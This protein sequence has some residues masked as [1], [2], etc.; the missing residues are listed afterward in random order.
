MSNILILSAGRRV[1]LLKGFQDA[2][3]RLGNCRVL[4]ADADPQMRAACHIADQAFVLPRVT[5]RDYPLALK[6]LCRKYDISLVIPTIDTELA[7]LADMR[8]EMAACGITLLVCCKNIVATFAD[9]RSTAKFFEDRGLNTPAHYP[10]SDLKFPLI[11]KPYDGALS[12]GVHLVCSEQEL[13]PAMLCNEKNIFCE[14]IDNKVHSEFTCDLYFNRHGDLKCVVPRKRLEIRGGEVSKGEVCKNDIVPLIFENFSHLDG[15]RGVMTIQLFRHNETKRS[16]F[17][18]VNP[19]FGGG[20]PLSRC[21]G[22]DY[23]AWLLQEY[24]AGQPIDVFDNWTD[25]TIMLRYDA[26]VIVKI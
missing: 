9:K 19:R 5:S 14:Y 24:L 4:A 20:Y 8:D 12:A 25:G 3:H 17:I 1:S 11:V 10:K 6:E 22:A 13:T 16:T 7:I 2:A 23:Q 18:E 26:E 15:A 21:A